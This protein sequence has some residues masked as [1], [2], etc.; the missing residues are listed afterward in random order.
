[1]AW[2]SSLV[3]ATTIGG[4][5]IAM[6]WTIDRFCHSLQPRQRSWL[7]RTLYVKFVFLLFCTSSLFTLPTIRFFNAGAKGDSIP[8]AATSVIERRASGVDLQ[9]WI[10]P[11][12]VVMGLAVSKENAL[13]LNSFVSSQVGK[14][15]MDFSTWVFLLILVWLGGAIGCLCHALSRHFRLMRTIRDASVQVDTRTEAILQK[16]VSDLRIASPPKLRLVALDCSPCL[17][18]DRQTYIV[19]P[20]DFA[21]RY[22]SEA[23]RMAIAHE[24]GHFVRGDL[25]WNGLVTAVTAWLF[26]FPPIWLMNRRYRIA[27]EMA[28]DAFTIDRAHVDRVSYASLLIGLLDSRSRWK[29]TTTFVAMA[30]SGSFRSLSTRLNA[31][32]LKK[33]GHF[34]LRAISL[35]MVGCVVGTLLMPWGFADVDE[36]KPRKKIKSTIESAATASI[37]T[38]AASES[39]N[40]VE[41]TSEVT[42]VGQAGTSAT[43]G[44]VSNGSSSSSASAKGGSSDGGS[45]SAA[46]AVTM[47]RESISKTTNNV[48]GKRSMSI[49]VSSK[50]RTIRIREGNN[51][52]FQV[53][54]EDSANGNSER[55]VYVSESRRGFAARHPEVFEKIKTYLEDRTPQAPVAPVAP[56]APKSRRSAVVAGMPLDP[57]SPSFP[58]LPTRVAGVPL[59]AAVSGVPVSPAVPVV[60][61][62]Q[63]FP[64]DP[65][66]P[67]SATVA[68]FPLVPSAPAH[69]V[70]AGFPLVPSV[71]AR[72]A[73][74]GFPI[75]PHVPAPA[76]VP[77]PPAPP[78]V[79]DVIEALEKIRLESA[80]NAEIERLIQSIKDK[81]EGKQ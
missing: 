17:I 71:P 51:G 16:I 41:Q 78:A 25:L 27:L 79:Q 7:W 43:G 52:E 36:T 47:K 69:S 80:G 44:A 67:A 35:V 62:V 65:N 6:F 22:G 53:E 40:S 9:T 56:V 50:D 21:D 5:A 57:N 2:Y 20:A 54:I 55:R 30:G 8:H 3:R 60:A 66:V 11:K 74:A 81:L 13:A 34:W 10:E 32:K 75:V 29:A 63:G 4:I 15:W 37:D 31:M 14:S 33:Q 61:S 49:E 39:S 77:A 45:S 24:L 68:G 72:T 28:C 59:V 38:R 58:G 42:I 1:M 18:W 46:R 12:E 76:A 64:L 48:D 70:V 73:V 26:F 23:C 19:L